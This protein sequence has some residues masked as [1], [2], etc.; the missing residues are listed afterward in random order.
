MSG[1]NTAHPLQLLDEDIPDALVEAVR[2]GQWSEPPAC[3]R[4]HPFATNL[5]L[6]L[7][8]LITPNTSDWS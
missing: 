1:S 8:P 4:H 2:D 6:E 7:V 5:R 3:Q